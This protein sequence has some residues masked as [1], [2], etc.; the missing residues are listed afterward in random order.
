MKNKLFS[1]FF[2]F[3]ANFFPGYAFGDDWPQFLGRDRSGVAQGTFARR[4]LRKTTPKI[5]WSIAVGEGYAG[6][7]VVGDSVL[8]LDRTDNARDVLRRIRLS[9]GKE[10]WRFEYSA[11]GSLS[12]NGSRT[13]PACDSNMVFTIGPFGHIRAVRFADGKPAWKAHLLDEWDAEQPWWGVSTS[14]LVMEDSVVVAPW[15]T[16]AALVAYEKSTGKVLWTTPN[17]KKFL[18]GYS[19]P[20]PMRLGNR[21][22][23]V[24]ADKH[25]RVIG[26]DAQTGKRLWEYSG[27]WCKI[28]IPSP[29]ILDDGR[30]LLT[31]GYRAGSAMIR[32]RAGDDGSFTVTELWK[33]RV[34]SSKIGQPLFYKNHIYANSSDTNDGLV[35]LTPGGKL[36]W[37]SGRAIRFGLGNILIADGLIFIIEGKSGTLVIVDAAPEKYTE[38]MR[39]RFLKGRRSWAPLAIARNALILRSQSEL[40]CVDMANNKQ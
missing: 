3:A 7:A 9:D 29:T 18:Q 6:P 12:Y 27:Y 23:I 40:I 19:S 37:K 32:V 30:V 22:M 4:D 20:V 26:A 10:R 16:L 31:G 14:P 33:S 17:P 28:H 21:L 24:A 34:L 1:L 38:L 13:T 36:K 39:L 35:C 25:G 8:L 2:I 11:P 15:G 5:R